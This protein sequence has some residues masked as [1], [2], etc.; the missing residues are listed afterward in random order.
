[1]LELG[2]DGTVLR[3]EGSA[4]LSVEQL[5]LEALIGQTMPRVRHHR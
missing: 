1:M 2:A 4:S 3:P 5:S